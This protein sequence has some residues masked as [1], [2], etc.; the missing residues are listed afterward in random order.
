MCLISNLFFRFKKHF[1]VLLFITLSSYFFCSF[2]CAAQSVSVGKILQ[3]LDHLQKLKEDV[4]AKVKIVQ[5]DVDQGKKVMESIYYAKDSSDL[6]L[7]SLTAPESEKGNG[8]LKVKKN[9]WMY[10]RNTRTFQ[11]ISRDESIAGTDA[12]AGDFEAPKYQKHYRGILGPDGT[13]IIEETILG[14]IPV[15]KVEILS[16]VVEVDYP[17]KILWVRKDNFLP[18]KEQSFSLSGTLMK[19]QYFLKYSQVDGKFIPV[20]QLVIDEFE[21]GNKTFWEI[22]DIS[23][24]PITDSVF[25]KAYLEN[26]SK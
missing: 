16:H 9:F 3:K 22:T 8:Y 20:K 6:F 19:T 10:R 18:L 7:I 4:T 26:L 15:Y 24:K 1:I 21:K 5:Q 2:S 13:E 17:K 14:K 25:T 12:N 11:H 23:F